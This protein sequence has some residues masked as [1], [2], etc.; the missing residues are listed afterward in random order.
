MWTGDYTGMAN[1]VAGM[2]R[3]INLGD[4]DVKL[5]QRNSDNTETVIFDSS[6]KANTGAI[7][8][9]TSQLTNDS[10]FLTNSSKAASASS[11]DSAT[12]LSTTDFSV[13]ELNGKLVIEYKGSVIISIDSTGLIKSGANIIGGTTP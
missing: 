4:G 12:S 6:T 11:A 2:K 3:W 5:V 7:P 8:T 1:L 10:N 13:S 9:K